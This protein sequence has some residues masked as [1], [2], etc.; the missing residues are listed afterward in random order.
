M[1]GI[2]G[3]KLGMTQI[4]DENGVAVPVTIIEAGPCY[5]TQKKTK[6][7]DGY[8][9]I[10]LGFAEINEKGLK[11]PIAG[12][13]KKTNTPA[14]KYMREFQVTNPDDYQEGQKID[15]SIFNVGDKVDITGVSKGKGFA[16][17]VKRHNFRGGPKT[18]GQSDRWR[19]PGSVGAGTTP[20]RVF[21]GMR[22]AGRMGNDQVTV[23]NLRVTL[24]DAAKNL[25]AVRGAIPG[26]KNGLIIIR[27]AVKG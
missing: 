14:I 21:K 25:L 10:Q 6:E 18:H 26:A 27:E 20:G 7:S 15:V 22:M 1:K 16:G 5:V 24:V 11:K 3:K 13:L 8:N 19:A 4:F 23:Q 12:H 2:L 17:T 9:A